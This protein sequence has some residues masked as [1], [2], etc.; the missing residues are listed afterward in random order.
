VAGADAVGDSVV[1][2]GRDSGQTADTAGPKPA[3]DQ[4]LAYQEYELAIANERNRA[5]Q[6]AHG[7]LRPWGEL[8]PALTLK[9]TPVDETEHLQR[10][11]FSIAVMYPIA[12]A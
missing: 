12:L 1:G 3:L 10:T 5:I 2:H 6:R 4:N 9:S 8:L 7:Y 11:D